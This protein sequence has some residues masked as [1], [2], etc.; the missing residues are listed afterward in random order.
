MI[1][2]LLRAYNFGGFFVMESESHCL[3]LKK[4]EL[5][6]RVPPQALNRDDINL[7]LLA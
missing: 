5:E 6:D 7:N 4:E 1:Y 3:R 2:G